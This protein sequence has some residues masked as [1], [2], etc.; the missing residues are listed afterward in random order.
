MNS[1]IPRQERGRAPHRKISD[2]WEEPLEQVRQELATAS[3]LTR[4]PD[5]VPTGPLDPHSAV[6]AI[7]RAEQAV[8]SSADK[9]GDSSYCSQLIEVLVQLSTARNAITE[10]QLAMHATAITEL[11]GALRDLDAVASVQQ[12]IE[13]VPQVIGQLGYDRALFSQVEDG[14]WIARSAHAH[15]D[16]DLARSMVEVGT[17]IPGVLKQNTPERH[18]ANKRIPVLVRDAQSN[19]EVHPELKTLI[20]TRS[21]VSAPVVVNDQ[22]VGLLHADDTTSARGVS[23]LDRDLL[24]LFAE[25]LGCI[26]ERTSSH[27]RLSLLKRKLE[28][29]TRAVT[30]VV[31]GC[32]EN[33]LSPAST[34]GHLAVPSNGTCLPR[35]VDTK[36]SGS[37]LTRRELEVLEHLAS[38]ERN[39]QIAARL[40]VSEGTVKT[41]VKSILRKL[42]ADNRAQAVARYHALV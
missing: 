40:Y 28:A 33:E 14:K 5:L 38:G 19:P 35:D 42:D 11:N 26:F 7:D 27:E 36:L 23:E 12:M 2:V 21:Y 34:D 37:G 16:N 29:E 30:D 3:E 6:R 39:A 13:R 22:T 17:A 31:D 8:M 18:V 25:G 15:A 24:G 4:T 20:Q 10:A 9:R 1:V 41:H 32:V